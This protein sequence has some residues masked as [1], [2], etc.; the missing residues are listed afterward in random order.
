M[1]IGGSVDPGPARTQVD[2]AKDTDNEYVNP[3]SKTAKPQ[4][5][6]D[7][8]NAATAKANEQLQV[9]EGTVTTQSERYG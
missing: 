2:I 4:W 7:Q 5:K 9:P 6:I 1:C 3:V 8:E